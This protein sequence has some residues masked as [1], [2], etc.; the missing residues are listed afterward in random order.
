M[1][2]NK[3]NNYE[4]KTACG[5][6][7]KYLKIIEKKKVQSELSF[8]GRGGLCKIVDVAFEEINK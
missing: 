6:I 3:R 1:N 8:L 4:I 7:K 5:K 2:K